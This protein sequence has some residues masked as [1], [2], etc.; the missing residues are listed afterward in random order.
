MSGMVQ[1]IAGIIGGIG[2]LI[3]IGLGIFSP[4]KYVLIGLLSLLSLLCLIIF[5][6]FYI[7][8]IKEISKRRMTELGLN[9][10]IMIVS[11]MFIIIVIN[12]IISQYYFRYDLSATRDFTLSPQ[13]ESIVRNLKE[14][15]HIKSFI[16]LSKSTYKKVN[17]LLEGYRYLNHRIVYSIY[18]L[19]AVPGIAQKFNVQKYN[20][21]VIVSGNRFVKVDG[22]DEESITNGIIRITRKNTKKI[23]ILQ[24]HG[25]HSVRSDGKGGIKTAIESLKA[26]GYDVRELNLTAVNAIPKDTSLLIIPGPKTKLNDKELEKLNA[27]ARNGR[28]LLMIDYEGNTMNEFLT[29]FGLALFKG[30]IVD[31]EKNLAGTDPTVPVVSEYPPNAITRDFTLTTFYPTVMAIVKNSGLERWYEYT[32]VV[33]SSDSSWLEV[34][35]VLPPVFTKDRDRKGPLNIAMLVNARQTNTRLMVF[36]DSH[37]IT[38]EYIDISGNGNLF[39]NV[40]SYLAG[41]E[42]IVNIEPPKT[43]FVPLYITDSQAREIMYIFVIGLPLIFGISGFTVWFIRRRW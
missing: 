21:T 25:E 8:S 3:A 34:D 22:V 42:D 38:N 6:V 33:R 26:M 31:P 28:V 27:Y 35:N 37:F 4:Q 20:T 11:F 40:V 2:A 36:G 16:Q 32:P 7:K 12:L 30:L 15:I 10:L 24:G 29:G 43:E 9:T 18:D 1:K 39:R 17:S 23:L 19:D 13:T 5:F 14:D 41:E